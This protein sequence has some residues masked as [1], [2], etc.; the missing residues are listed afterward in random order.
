MSDA[1]TSWDCVEAQQGN[2]ACQIVF[3][4]LHG[5]A[6]SY[7]QLKSQHCMFSYVFAQ[8]T[9]ST[10]RQATWWWTR[11]AVVVKTFRV[12]SETTE[13]QSDTR[14]EITVYAL[15]ALNILCRDVRGSI[16]QNPIQSNPWMNPIHGHLCTRRALS[17][18]STG[19]PHRHLRDW[20]LTTF[21]AVL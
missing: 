16:F 19:S 20:K 1:H 7:Q 13:E 21:Y 5:R 15:R 10:L 2:D 6:P 17:R 3:F 12:P 14:P 9:S 8:S 4:S 11:P 18:E